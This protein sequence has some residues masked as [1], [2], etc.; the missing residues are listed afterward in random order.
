MAKTSERKRAVLFSFRLIRD[1][2]NI[3]FD[4]RIGLHVERCQAFKILLARLTKQIQLPVAPPIICC[5]R[6]YDLT[7]TLPVELATIGPS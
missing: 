2:R 5:P 3:S 6:V 7:I 4:V 1:P